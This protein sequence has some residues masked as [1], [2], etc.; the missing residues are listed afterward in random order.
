[1]MVQR[2]KRTSNI[3]AWYWTIFKKYF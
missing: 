3:N 1:M 2:E